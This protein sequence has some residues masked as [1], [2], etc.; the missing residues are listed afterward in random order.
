M[1]G[2]G[3]YEETVVQMDPVLQAKH[4]LRIQKRH[5]VTLRMVCPSYTAIERSI[6]AEIKLKHQVDVEVNEGHILRGGPDTLSSTC[7]DV[8]IDNIP[9]N[10]IFTAI[11]M[12]THTTYGEVPSMMGIAGAAKLYEYG[13]KVGILFIFYLFLPLSLCPFQPISHCQSRA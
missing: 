3:T 10:H 2:F 6:I 9:V 5:L 4:T 12:L 11:V 7:F 8:H 1:K 13:P